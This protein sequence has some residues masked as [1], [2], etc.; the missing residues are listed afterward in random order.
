MGDDRNPTKAKINFF[1]I[2]FLTPQAPTELLHTR[3][4][5]HL[6]KIDFYLSK[7][8]FFPDFSPYCAML[9]QNY[10]WQQINPDF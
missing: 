2:L 4:F 6:K 1:E 8:Q 7:L 5:F 3:I 9:S 10:R